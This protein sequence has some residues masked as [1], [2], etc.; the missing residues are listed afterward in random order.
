MNDTKRLI[1]SIVKIALGVGLLL[2]SFWNLLDPFWSGMGGAL[3]GIGVLRLAQQ[4]KYRANPSY[5]DEVDVQ[6]SDERNQYLRMKAWAWAGYWFVLIAAAAVILLKLAGLDE[7]SFCI[8]M[9]LCL[10]LVLYWL[11]YM[12]LQKKY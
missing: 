4:I 1:A 11:S 7:F 3:I 6:S 2:A 8:S 9:A 10:V 12:I 5:R